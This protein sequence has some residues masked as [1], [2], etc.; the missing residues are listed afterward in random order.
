M[1]LHSI[2]HVACEDLA[3]IGDWA[4]KNAHKVTVTRQY[5]EESL[6]AP[7][8]ID[9]LVVLGGP[10][11]VHEEK[12]YPW[13]VEE[14]DF[15]RDCIYEG[16]RVLG[17]CLGAQLISHVLGGDVAPMGYREIG[18]WPVRLTDQARATSIF[19]DWPGEFTAMHW[20]GDQFSIPP[21]AVHIAGNDAC[22]HQAF[23]F[24]NRVT[25]LQFHLEETEA[26]T[27]ALLENWK[28]E[29][30]EGG[31]YVQNADA[32][33]QGYCNLPATKALLEKLLDAWAKA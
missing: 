30:A 26:A 6:P 23:I 7:E 12:K 20:H 17:V 18:W 3:A 2:Q 31:Q 1:R 11:S 25:A 24:R 33:R 19:N 16:K 13:L 10:M 4:E 32:I 29:M 21:G 14:K 8:Q 9:A 27:E 22:P 5:A 15:I 28:D